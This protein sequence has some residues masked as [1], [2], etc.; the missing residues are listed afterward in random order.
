MIFHRTKLRLSWTVHELS[1][2][3]KIQ[4]LTFIRQAMYVFLVH[5]KG[6]LIKSWSTS[7]DLSAYKISWSHVDWC[8]FYIHLRSLKI[9]PLPYSKVS[10]KKII[11]WIRLVGTF[12][13]FHCTKLRLSKCNSSWVVS[14]KQTVNFKFQPPVMFVFVVSHKSGLIKSCW[15]SEDLSEHKIWWSYVDWWMFCI[16]LGSM[17]VWHFGMVSAILNIRVSRLPS[18]TWPSYWIS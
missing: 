9:P 12:M 1:S 18:L 5:H 2:Q 3:N 7:E 13:I 4:I 6:G 8:K 16:H 10:L 17:N 11:I 14:I 15:P